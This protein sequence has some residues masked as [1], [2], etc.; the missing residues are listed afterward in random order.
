MGIETDKAGK[1]RAHVEDSVK[2][3]R[4][5][6]HVLDNEQE[7]NSHADIYDASPA[8]PGESVCY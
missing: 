3:L 1:I 8:I 6:F 5:K 2:L 4:R 7:L